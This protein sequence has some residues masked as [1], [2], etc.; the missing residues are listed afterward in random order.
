MYT[1]LRTKYISMTWWWWCQLCTRPTLFV[2]Y[3]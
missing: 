2:V 1:K 3:F